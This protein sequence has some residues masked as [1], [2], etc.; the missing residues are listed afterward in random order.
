M[1]H[2]CELYWRACYG[3]RASVRNKD[4][5]RCG[6][7]GSAAGL[8]RTHD[9]GRN[10]VGAGAVFG[11]CLCV[12]RQARRSDQ[13]VVVRRRWVVFIPEEAGARA[14]HLA[15]SHERHRSSDEGAVIDAF[16]RH[17][18]APATKNMGTTVGRMSHR[19]LICHCYIS[20]AYSVR[21]LMLASL[22]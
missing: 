22:I 1:P 21:W 3:D 18:L 13:A 12:P 19:M 9:A 10:S 5:D 8:S 20:V 17:R 16:G 6:L 2:W 11:T 14:L 4:M 15:A 7:H